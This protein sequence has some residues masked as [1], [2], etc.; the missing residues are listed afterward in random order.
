MVC[1]S[2]EPS[3]RPASHEFGDDLWPLAQPL[4][5]RGQP[6]RE[7]A[8]RPPAKT[9]FGGGRHADDGLAI[10]AV[11]VAG[12]DHDHALGRQLARG[13]ER[14]RIALRLQLAERGER[15]QLPAGAPVELVDRP[16]ELDLA[17]DRDDEDVRRD[18]PGLV[19]DDT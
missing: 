13:R 14:G 11:G 6:E 9:A 7:G 12:G 10:E 4:D 1:G 15:A 16:L 3:M 8:H 2:Y 5:Q 17:D 19:G 18:I